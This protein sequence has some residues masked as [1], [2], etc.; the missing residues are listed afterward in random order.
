MRA[1]LL[2]NQH[3][4]IFNRGFHESFLLDFHV[5]YGSTIAWFS[6]RVRNP[7]FQIEEIPENEYYRKQINLFY[8]LKIEQIFCYNQHHY[9]IKCYSTL[10]TG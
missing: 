6:S 9:G 4:K 1:S 8:S 7:Q 5:D 10:V 3:I 2:K